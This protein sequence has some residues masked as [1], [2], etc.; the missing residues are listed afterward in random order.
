MIATSVYKSKVEVNGKAA[1]NE[2]LSVYDCK[3]KQIEAGPFSTDED[4][5]VD[6]TAAP[7]GDLCVRAFTPASTATGPVHLD[8]K[9]PPQVIFL[10]ASSPQPPWVEKILP[11][12][13]CL[14]TMLLVIYPIVRYLLKPWINRRNQLIGQ[15][16]NPALT[17]YYKQFRRGIYENKGPDANYA[18]LFKVDFNAWYGRGFYFIPVAGLFILSAVC[19]W[20]S[21]STL[22]SWIQG[23]SS[24]NSM[25]GLVA[26]AI[27]GAFTWII[28]GE[29]DRLRRRDFTSSDVYYYLFRLLLCVPFGWSLS[30]IAVSLDVAIPIAFFLGAFPTSTL[31]TIA[32][33]FTNERLKLGDSTT[34]GLLELE[35]LQSVGKE[36]AERFKDEGISTIV[37]LAYTDPLD[38]TIRSNFEFN[39]VL[40]F[41]SQALLWIYFGEKLKLLQIYSLRS[42]IEAHYLYRCIT[43]DNDPQARA[44]VNAIVD[45]LNR[46]LPADQLTRAAAT[47]N[48]AAINLNATPNPQQNQTPIV[49]PAIT[50][51][52]LMTTLRQVAEDPYTLFICKIWT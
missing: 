39:Y 8:K 7:E 3:S 10:S 48:Q 29:I 23:L 19:V 5:N 31:F 42:A 13:F 44:T 52:V 21:T 4:G 40:D 18:V 41:I 43:D 32:R 6:I 12:S 16:G 22:W 33:R 38:L 28:S 9:S 25:R 30:R 15:L 17:L 35:S 49:P 24:A 36:I 50:F 37:Q 34:S 26:A 45:S 47:L 27:A 46:S 1:P 11:L 20:W 51:E 14:F 2:Q